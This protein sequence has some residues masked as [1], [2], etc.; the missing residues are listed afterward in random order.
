MKMIRKRRKTDLE[1]QLLLIFCCQLPTNVMLI[2]V[3]YSC[4]RYQRL[5][6]FYVFILNGCKSMARASINRHKRILGNTN[7]DLF[8]G[9]TTIKQKIQEQ[10][11][12]NM[13]KRKDLMMLF[14]ALY[15]GR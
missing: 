4:I 2:V 5:M 13:S 12:Q 8:I 11:N 7:L 9:T 14:I 3:A 1:S 15:R 6:N 10:T